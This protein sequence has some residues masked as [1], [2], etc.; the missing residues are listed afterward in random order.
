MMNCSFCV[1]I[2]FATVH[3]VSI[4]TETVVQALWLR[5]GSGNE[6]LAKISKRGN[7]SGMN[8]E[9]G[10]DRAA[11]V[12]CGH[13]TPWDL[14]LIVVLQ[15]SQRLRKDIS[16]LIT[17]TFSAPMSASSSALSQPSATSRGNTC[18]KTE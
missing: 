17:S 15:L 12:L 16:L 1:D 14:E 5:G 10:N 2:S 6:S 18:I 7:L 9:V 3:F 8:L 4:K 13:R 11:S